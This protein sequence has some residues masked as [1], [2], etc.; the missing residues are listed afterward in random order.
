MI[1]PDKSNTPITWGVNGYGTKYY[2]CNY[3]FLEFGDVDPY[4]I[5]HKC[6]IDKPRYH[7]RDKKKY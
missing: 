6:N 7:N 3:C 4:E 2:L 5:E 1:K